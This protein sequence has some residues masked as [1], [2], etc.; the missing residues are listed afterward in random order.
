MH[1]DQT[2]RP[3]EE[4]VVG[5]GIT[6]IEGQ[7]VIAARIQSGGN[8]L[9]KSL[10]RLSVPFLLLGAEPSGPCGNGVAFDEYV[11][12]PFVRFYPE[13]QQGIL[14][15][16]TQKHGRPHPGSTGTQ[17]GIQDGRYPFAGGGS[18]AVCIIGTR[19]PG[20]HNH[21]NCQNQPQPGQQHVFL[22]ETRIAFP[23]VFTRRKQLIL[24]ML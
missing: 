13:F 8:H 11:A 18:P 3:V 19:H 6:D 4:T 7:M 5:I 10:R 17:K 12:L 9:I 22:H 2:S 16:G 14:L 1:H 20:N 21:T 23:S 15:H 24:L